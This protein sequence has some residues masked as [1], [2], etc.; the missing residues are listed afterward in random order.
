M[1]EK[2]KSRLPA[3]P[4]FLK[5]KRLASGLSQLEIAKTLG[6]SSGQ[7]VSNWE[8]GLCSPPMVNIAK[9]VSV[10]NIDHKEITEIII[11]ET[12]EDLA[13]AFN[14][15]HKKKVATK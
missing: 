15:R 12:R 4:V 8:R 11:N 2:K 7:F 13:K 1:S 3:L 9:L 10:L 6:Y 5:E 14:T